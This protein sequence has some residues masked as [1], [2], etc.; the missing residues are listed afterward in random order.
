MASLA[1]LRHAQA[2]L[3]SANYDQL[4]PLGREQA[5]ALGRAWRERA[6][7]FDRVFT[8][9]AQR[10]RDTFAIAR[11]AS[12]LDLPSPTVLDGFDEHDAFALVR[13]AAPSRIAADPT[14]AEHARVAASSD[15]DP[16]ARSRAWQRLFES[17]MHAW[18]DDALEVANIEPWTAFRDRVLDA[19]Q[20]VVDGG[21]RRVLVVSSVG[22]I[23]A[24]LLRA[25]ALDPH[26]AFET[27]W[28]TRNCAIAR[29]LF[30]HDR[31]TLDAFNALDHLPDPTHHTHR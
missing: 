3:L 28:R 11:D 21:G 13:S 2:S 24:V 19:L 30:S 9:P 12:G 22:P 5:R 4:S 10:H 20:T 14:L 1:L 8:G 23:A 16:L 18:L 25:L 15:A 29:F 27:A 31:L 6:P 17:V 7:E 26:V